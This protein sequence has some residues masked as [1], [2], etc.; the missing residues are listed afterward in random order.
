MDQFRVL[1][2]RIT[3]ESI[4]HIINQRGREEGSG[5]RYEAEQDGGRTRPDGKVLK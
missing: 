3:P 1:G 5:V 2:K 4:A